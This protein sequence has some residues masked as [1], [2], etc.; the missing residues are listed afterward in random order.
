MADGIVSYINGCSEFFASQSGLMCKDLEADSMRSM[1]NSVVAQISS[2]PNLQ[3]ADA[4]TMNTALTNSSFT[5]QLKEELARAVHAKLTAVSSD[6]AHDK[7]HQVM[8]HPFNYLATSDWDS[9]A[10]MAKTTVHAATIVRQRLQLCG[11]E[12]LSDKNLWEFGRDD[13][14]CPGT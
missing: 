5:I 4:T 8:T 14:R 12:R 9:I 11:L 2:L 3:P 7:G 1:A 6:A 13:R 10:D